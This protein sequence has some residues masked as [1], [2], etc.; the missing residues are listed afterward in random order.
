MKPTRCHLCVIFISPLQVA[1]HVSGNHVPIFRSWRLRSVIAT[2]WYCAVT[3][4]GIIHICLSVGFDM[5]YV[6]LVYCK[7]S[8]SGLC[9]VMWGVVGGSLI[10]VCR[11][12]SVCNQIKVH[13]GRY[14]QAVRTGPQWTHYLLTGLDSLPAATGMYFNLLT[15][16]TTPTYNNE[17]TTHN[18]PHNHTQPTHTRFTINQT[19]IEHIDRTDRRIWIIPIIVT[20]QYQHVAIT[21]RSRQILKMGTWLPETCWATCKGEIKI[22]HKWHL[23]GFL[24]TLIYVRVYLRARARARVCVC[25]CVCLCVCNE[26]NEEKQ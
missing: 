26:P 14:M 24:S 20:A 9:V 8:V 17:T 11:C 3:M 7:S 25:V 4:S 12:G 10:V 13:T 21:L 15:H 5:F 1:Q 16:R 18:T 2:C 22:T 23:V 19:N 6:C